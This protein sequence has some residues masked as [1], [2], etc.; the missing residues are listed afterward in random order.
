MVRGGLQVLVCLT[1]PLNDVLPRI[2]LIKERIPMRELSR[3][4]G[5]PSIGQEV[6]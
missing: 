5:A 6:H 2:E 4:K 1:E 3:Y